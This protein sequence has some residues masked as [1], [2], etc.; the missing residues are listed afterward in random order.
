MASRH[1]NLSSRGFLLISKLC[2]AREFGLKEGDLLKVG[3]PLL[4]RV[5]SSGDEQDQGM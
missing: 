2:D 4:A 5:Q 3:V 1:C